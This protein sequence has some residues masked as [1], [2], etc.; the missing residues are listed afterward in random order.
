MRY[1]LVLLRKETEKEGILELCPSKKFNIEKCWDSVVF[2]VIFLN[3]AMFQIFFYVPDFFYVF[4]K[5][6]GKNDRVP[7]FF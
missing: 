6:K 7:T 2:A 3:L 5:N 4:L 1:V